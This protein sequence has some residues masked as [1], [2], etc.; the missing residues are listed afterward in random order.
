MSN[1][2]PTELLWINGHLEQANYGYAHYNMELNKLLSLGTNAG[3]DDVDK[4]NKAGDD[5]ANEII[6]AHL[7]W[8]MSDDS[9]I[10]NFK[11]VVNMFL[12][13]SDS[14]DAKIYTLNQLKEG[15][16]DIDHQLEDIQDQMITSVMTLVFFCINS[17]C[18]M[19]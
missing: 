14:V 18:I 1:V 7:N 11:N 15:V 6:K 9:D 19:F 5:L 8:M 10:Y 3:K 12:N 13:D 2:S 4:F 16:V 17:S